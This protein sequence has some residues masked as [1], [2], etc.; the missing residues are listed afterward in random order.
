M[1]RQAQ[2][3]RLEAPS[4][5]TIAEMTLYPSMTEW[6]ARPLPMDAIKALSPE[7]KRFGK[8]AEN[9]MSRRKTLKLR[10]LLYRDDAYPTPREEQ[11]YRSPD[12]D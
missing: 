1:A 9:R 7:A 11:P 8:R 12:R 4:L 2:H 6:L 5:E 10:V 3:P